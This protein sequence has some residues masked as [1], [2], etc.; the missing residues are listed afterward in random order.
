MPKLT[1]PLEKTHQIPKQRLRSEN[2]LKLFQMRHKLFIGSH[3]LKFC[4]RH[5]SNCVFLRGKL[6]TSVLKWMVRGAP[7]TG[8]LAA[9]AEVAAGATAAVAATLHAGTVDHPVTRPAT[10]AHVPAPKHPLDS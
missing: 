3:E 10:A 1:E 4:I 8:A 2:T 5:F 7:V 6:P 9:A